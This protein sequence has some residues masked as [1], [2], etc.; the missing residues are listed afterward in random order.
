MRAWSVPQNSAQNSWYS[1]GLVAR[2]HI[3]VKRPGSTSC[4]SR[5]AGTKKLWMTSCEVITSRIASPRGTC[6][7]LIS[8]APLG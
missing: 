6:R 8:R 1:P 3:S 7:A 2:N 5:K 4:F